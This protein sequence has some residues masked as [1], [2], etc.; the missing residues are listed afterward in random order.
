M[1]S[2]RIESLAAELPPGRLVNALDGESDEPPLWLSD[3]PVT[4]DLWS[5]VWERCAENGLWPLIL[6]SSSSWGGGF[7]PWA[8][9]EL[10]P[11]R[12]ERI[13]E[14]DAGELLAGWWPQYAAPKQEVQDDEDLVLR[15]GIV[16][17][18]GTQ[19]PGLAAAI[20]SEQAAD[21]FARNY[22]DVLL[23]FGGDARLGLVDAGSGAQALVALG[24][25]GPANY[26]PTREFAAV[27]ASWEERFG[28]RVV[29]LT[30][31]TLQ[32]SVAA[33][34][35]TLD[36]A[37][38]VAA[39]HFAF[40]PDNVWQGMGPYTLAAYAEGLVDAEGWHFWWD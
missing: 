17:P 27:V 20:N 35:T 29:L 30:G 28:A 18:F 34:P 26:G 40:C 21:A 8:N 22:G 25:A 9:G 39:E 7:R 11:D 32:L 24:W 5:H 36:E 16:A 33:P 38:R 15:Q 6:D 3:E 2:G 19:W 1:I 14:L 31:D 37:L 10:W 13:A 23:A 4:A 12:V